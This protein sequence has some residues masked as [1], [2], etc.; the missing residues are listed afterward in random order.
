[1]FYLF[2]LAARRFS[3]VAASGGYSSL[4]CAAAHCGGLSRCGAWALGAQASAVVA[5]GLSSCGSRAPEH[6]LSSCGAGAQL[7]RG[8]WDPPRTGIEPVSPALTGGFPT[9][10]PPGNSHKLIFL[11]GKRFE[12]TLQQRRY[13]DDKHMEGCSLSVIREMQI[14]T[15]MRYQYWN[16]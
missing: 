1:M 2:I 4:R 12:Q 7:L 9:T 6:R 10:A 8:M 5:R 13:T 11:K 14:K 3:L 15:T 16:S